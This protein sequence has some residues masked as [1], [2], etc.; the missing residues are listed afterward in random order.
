[1]TQQPRKK[2]KLNIDNTIQYDDQYDDQT[3]NNLISELLDTILNDIIENIDIFECPICYE[4]YSLDKKITTDC[5]HIFCQSCYDKIDICAMCRTNL[6]KDRLPPLDNYLLY[7]MVI[8]DGRYFWPFTN[9]LITQ[10][11]IYDLDINII[12]LTT[13][14]T[15][16]NYVPNNTPNPE[17]NPEQNPNNIL[18][19][20]NGSSYRINLSDYHNSNSPNIES[21]IETQQELLIQSAIEILN[22]INIFRLFENR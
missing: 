14:L 17:Q 12:D 19:Y 10:I 22:Y 16:L 20:Y 11:P 8:Y 6:N 13:N 1:M 9:N 7:D 2:R 18:I 15:D 4:K 5:N 3:N 21:Y